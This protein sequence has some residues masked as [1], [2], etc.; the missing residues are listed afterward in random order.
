MKPQRETNPRP[1]RES[2]HKLTQ[3]YLTITCHQE[4]GDNYAEGAVFTPLATVSVYVH[5]DDKTTL[6]RMMYCGHCFYR[7]WDKA[8]GNRTLVTLARVF[9]EEVING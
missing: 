7:S 2:N 9:A 5:Y 3:C 1:V 4:D 8:Y 6:L